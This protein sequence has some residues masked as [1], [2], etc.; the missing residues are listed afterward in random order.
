MRLPKKYRV[1]GVLFASVTLLGSWGLLG[2]LFVLGRIH[3]PKLI[4]EL[5]AMSFWYALIMGLPPLMATWLV[6][7]FVTPLASSDLGIREAKFGVTVLSALLSLGLVLCASGISALLAFW[8]VIPQT[9]LGNAAEP[10]DAT[11]GHALLLLLAFFG[12]LSLLWFQA[13]I[14]ELG[15]RGYFLMRLIK[16]LGPWGV[17]VHGLVWGLWYTPLLLFVGGWGERV[18]GFFVGLALLG[19]LFAWLRLW[20]NCLSSIVIANI[21][22]TVAAGLPYLL[23]GREVGLRG[24]LFEPSG[25]LLMSCILLFL[26]LWRSDLLQKPVSLVQRRF[27]SSGD[28][29]LH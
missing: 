15:W 3:P 16:K 14:E 1:G 22:V 20:T 25:W 11:A 6:H 17:L 26:F 12:T 21:T 23:H 28:R 9:A 5:F 8:E 19:S 2:V 29:L 10:V 13:L 24:A 27:D 4:T 7:R 18:A